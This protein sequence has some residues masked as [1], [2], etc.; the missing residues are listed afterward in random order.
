MIQAIFTLPLIFILG[1]ID[2]F[3]SVFDPPIF[4]YF[5]AVAIIGSVAMVLYL[6]SFNVKNISISSIFLSLSII[7][8]T[9]IGRDRIPVEV[10]NEYDRKI[11]C[12]RQPGS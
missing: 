7:V 2:E 11:H 5:I 1:L 4:P 6:R 10:K 12:L 9:T 3:F 8:S